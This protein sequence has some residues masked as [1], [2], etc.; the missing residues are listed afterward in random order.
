MIREKLMEAQVRSSRSILE[1]IREQLAEVH[2]AWT[3]VEGE[4]GAL[5][6]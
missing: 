6:Q 3:K 1:Q 2:A 5:V 4:T